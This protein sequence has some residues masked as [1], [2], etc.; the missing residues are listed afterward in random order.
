LTKIICGLH[1]INHDEARRGRTPISLA[2]AKLGREIGV[3]FCLKKRDQAL[4]NI[5]NTGIILFVGVTPEKSRF[6]CYY[7]VPKLSQR[8]RNRGGS[9]QVGFF[10]ATDQPDAL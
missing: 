4:D 3:Y 6:D 9:N 1:F 10:L 7:P 5:F 8:E 2:V